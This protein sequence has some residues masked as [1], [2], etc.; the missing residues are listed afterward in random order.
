MAKRYGG[1]RRRGRKS[2]AS[3]RLQTSRNRYRNV[4]GDRW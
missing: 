3:K 4:I 2:Y 1:R